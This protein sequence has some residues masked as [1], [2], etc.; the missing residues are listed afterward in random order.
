MFCWVIYDQ[1][2]F[3]KLNKK[4][5]HIAWGRFIENNQAKEF[6]TKDILF[7]CRTL[8]KICSKGLWNSYDDVIVEYSSIKS[9][10]SV[11]AMWKFFSV[12]Y[13]PSKIRLL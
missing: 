8:I 3:E 9:R 7:I 13:Q 4:T 5:A 12:K 2:K 6:W 1:G 11:V 10:P